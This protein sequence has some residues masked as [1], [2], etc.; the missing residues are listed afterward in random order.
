MPCNIFI[1]TML[2]DDSL[3][4]HSADTFDGKSTIDKQFNTLDYDEDTLPLVDEPTVSTAMC[5]ISD[6]ES[7]GNA[8]L[9]SVDVFEVDD[10]SIRFN[11]RGPK[12]VPRNECPVTICTDNTIGTAKSRRI[13]RVLLD[14]GAS[15]CLIKRSAF[16]DGVVLKELSETKYVKTLGGRLSSAE[17]VTMRD[18]CVSLNSTRIDK[19]INRKP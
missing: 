6:N 12:V 18:T 3:T 16:P 11:Y 8:F 14:S 4:D 9:M 19:L 1:P 13:F 2:D 10:E 7:A 5:T 15:A 17:V